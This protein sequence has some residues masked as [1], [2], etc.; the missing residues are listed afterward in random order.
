MNE[1]PSEPTTPPTKTLDVRGYLC[2]IPARLAEQAI[3][4]LAPGDHLEILGDDPVMIIDIPAWCDDKGH[5][6]L[7]C[8][9][10]GKLV[11]C[12]VEKR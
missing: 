4:E 2:P 9:K 12:T 1:S 10:D 3:Q 7:R 11:H 6:L 8:E 5:H